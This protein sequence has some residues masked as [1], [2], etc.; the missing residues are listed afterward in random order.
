MRQ[1]H[2]P[3]LVV[4]HFNEK[5]TNCKSLLV[6]VGNK[7]S[8]TL[9][10]ACAHLSWIPELLDVGIQLALPCRGLLWAHLLQIG[11]L[12]TI[13]TQPSSQCLALPYVLPSRTG[14]HR[15]PLTKRETKDVYICVYIYLYIYIYIYTD[16]CCEV[17]IWS[18]FGPFGSYYLVQVCF[19]SKTPIAKKHYKNR[20]F[21]PFFLEKKIVHKNFGSCYLVQ[22]GV[23]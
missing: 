11:R 14:G 5:D 20:G 12:A 19:F 18:K 10:Q 8:E 16:I 2:M 7:G 3:Y 13:Q 22:V 1:W 4:F 6:N 9:W 17:I 23:F 21:S 15:D